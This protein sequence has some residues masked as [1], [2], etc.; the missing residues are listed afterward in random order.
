[1][2]RFKKG[3]ANG[4]GSNIETQAVLDF[5][6]PSRDIPGMLPDLLKVEV[7][8]QTN[9]LGTELKEVSVVARNR[10]RR[11]WA[12]PLQPATTAEII[13]LV[14]NP[15]EATPSPVV[16]TPKKPSEETVDEAPK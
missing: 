10:K 6:D 16:V 7:C 1:L 2:I 12:Y 4:V 15:A 14:T 8:Y 13:T 3:N 9:A 5:V 11:V